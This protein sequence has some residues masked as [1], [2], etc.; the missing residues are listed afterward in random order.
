VL[1]DACQRH[2]SAAVIEFY[3]SW[4]CRHANDEII[5]KTV[6]ENN[7]NVQHSSQNTFIAL[8]FIDVTKV[9]L[10]VH[11]NEL[12]EVDMLLTVDSTDSY[13]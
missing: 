7:V 8:Q 1:T 5:P 2:S 3:T 4:R 11:L 6:P 9:V 13:W 12:Q 10:I